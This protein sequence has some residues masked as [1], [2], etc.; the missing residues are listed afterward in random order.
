MKVDWLER[1][2][3]SVEE[4]IKEDL[5]IFANND[6]YVFFLYDFDSLTDIYHPLNIAL[7]Y[8]ISRNALWRH[9][10]CPKGSDPQICQKCFDYAVSLDI[11]GPWPIW[12]RPMSFGKHNKFEDGCVF[13]HWTDGNV[14]QNNLEEILATPK[15]STQ[16]I[17]EINK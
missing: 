7:E 14:Y 9:H 11:D 12:D 5:D 2:L 16:G 13:W 15:Y 1:P 10:K 6:D 4:H 8:W 3:T 17:E